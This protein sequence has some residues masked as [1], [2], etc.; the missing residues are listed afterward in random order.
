MY[1]PAI[2]LTVI[3]PKKT[4]IQKDICTPVFVAVLFTIDKMWKQPKCQ[5]TEEWIK[6]MW[7]M[8]IMEYYSATKRMG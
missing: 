4:I 6:K 8:Y 5:L 7:H 2:Q 1:D 3:Y